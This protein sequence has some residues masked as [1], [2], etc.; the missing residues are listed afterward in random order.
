MATGFERSVQDLELNPVIHRPTSFG[1]IGDQRLGLTKTNHAEPI[2]SDPLTDKV[3]FDRL[4][5]LIG[6]AEML[7]FAVTTGVPFNPDPLTL[8]SLQDVN[9]AIQFALVI[10]ANKT[11]TTCVD[12]LISNPSPDER[13][14]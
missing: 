10:S 6:Q 8:M 7:F 13:T 14:G 12:V 5:A 9:H 3:G 11:L 2:C 1:L 4:G